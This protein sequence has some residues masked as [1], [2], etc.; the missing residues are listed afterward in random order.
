MHQWAVLANTQTLKSCY[1]IGLL[2]GSALSLIAQGEPA[3]SF[4]PGEAVCGYAGSYLALTAGQVKLGL[5]VEMLA[6]E[7]LVSQP[8]PLRFRVSQKPQGTLVDDL[9]VEHEKLMHVIAVRDDLGAFVHLHP[10]RAAPG[11]WEI[12]HT[13]TNAGRYQIWSDIKH[14]G[15]VYSF[16]QP[17]FVVTGERQDVPL[18]SVP[19]LEDEIDGYQVVLKPAQSPLVAGRTNSFEVVVRDRLGNSIGTEFFLG[20]LMHLIIVKDDLSTY[21]HAHA[22]E[23][24]KS[25]E[26]V[27]FQHI[28]PRTGDYKIFAQFRP[29][30]TRLPPDEALLAEFWVRVERGN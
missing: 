2:V 27:S 12:I 18:G 1:F 23:H 9:Q 16:A 28:F 21:A 7:A 17:R 24:L 13:F 14:R 10:Q 11:L 15:T 8:V 26:P 6:G 25:R 29:Q 19:K 4:P 5:S 3:R 20:A 30:K 22:V